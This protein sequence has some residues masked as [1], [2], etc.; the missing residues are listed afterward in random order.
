MSGKA[1]VRGPGGSS[2]KSE[3][4]THESYMLKADKKTALIGPEPLA[5]TRRGIDVPFVPRIPLQIPQPSNAFEAVIV[6]IIRHL[7]AFE[8]VQKK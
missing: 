7:P 4:P 8:E 2:E 6:E 1:V 3:A 5:L